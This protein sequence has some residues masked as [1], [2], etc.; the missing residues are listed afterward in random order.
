MTHVVPL[1]VTAK[2]E[3]SAIGPCLESLLEAAR[4]AEARLPIHWDVLVVLDDCTD[5]T[6]EIA[7]SFDRVRTLKSSGGLVEAQRKVGQPFQAGNQAGKPDL[8]VA[9]QGEFVIFSDADILVRPET[10]HGLAKAML[11][12]RRVQAAYPPKSPLP[13]RRQTLLARALH[14]YNQSD[15]FQTRRHYFNGKLFAIRDWRVPTLGDLAPRLAN[16]P[17]DRFY[18]FHAGMR[19]DDIWLSRDILMR[20]GPQAIVETS[21]GGIC[22]HPPETFQGMY[23]T[24][25]RMRMEIERLNLL[26]PETAPTHQRLG[27]R[28]YDRAAVRAATPQQR[29]LWRTFRVALAACKMIYCGERFYYQHISHKACDPWKP[30]LESKSLAS[31]AIDPPA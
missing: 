25:R 5:G 21:E 8:Q 26:F 29:F 28:T 13:P 23:R 15:G 4:Y 20:H 24:Y 7:R 12:D 2:N 27:R 17:V 19:V 22:F 14:Q 6:G 16:L 10:L 3:Q 11:D 18:D 9:G 1:A 30:I 31:S